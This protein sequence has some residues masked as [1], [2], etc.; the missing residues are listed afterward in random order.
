M[1]CVKDEEDWLLRFDDCLHKGLVE[2][3]SF[4]QRFSV[5]CMAFIGK[6]GAGRNIGVVRVSL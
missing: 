6:M 4:G 2:T 5:M 1:G 3:A